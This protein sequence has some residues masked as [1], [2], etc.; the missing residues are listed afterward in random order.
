M[1]D[2]TLP[3]WTPRSSR[4]LN[5]FAYRHAWAGDLAR[6]LAKDAVFLVVAVAVFAFL[7]AGRYASPEARR[8]A[9]SAV[10]A[11]LLALLVAKLLSNAVGRVRPY[12]AHDDVH[13]LSHAAR[14][15]GFPSDHATSAFAIG[16]A[17]VLRNRL[18]GAIALTLA[19][20]IAVARVAVGAHYPTDVLGGA[21]IG[22]AAALLCFFT[23]WLRRPLDRLA[24]AC[25]ALYERLIG[26]RSGSLSKS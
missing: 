2:P 13:L 26:P 19:V 15:P 14:D 5:D 25:G 4:S 22:T 21:A 12:L 20:L 11:L 8:G 18:A 6:F 23:P 9:V 3:P 7:A 24:D 1:R 17:L 16:V 10:V